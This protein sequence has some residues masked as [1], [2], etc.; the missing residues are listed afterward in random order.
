MNEYLKILVVDDEFIMR[1]GIAHMID[2][3]QEGFQ[4]I[5]QASNGLEALELIKQN[6]PDI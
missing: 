6:V 2:W 1:Q 3:E 4:I 5:G